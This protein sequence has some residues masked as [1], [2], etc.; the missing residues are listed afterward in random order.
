MHKMANKLIP[1][2][3]SLLQKLRV[4]SVSEEIPRQLWN[5]NI[6]FRVYKNPPPARVLSQLN[7]THT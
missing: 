3:R 6:L 4:L 5:S 2:I 7:P 1:W